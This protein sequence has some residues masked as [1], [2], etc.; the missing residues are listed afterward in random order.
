LILLTQSLTPAPANPQTKAQAQALLTEGTALYERGDFAGALDRFQAAY[1]IYPSPKLQFNIAQADRD[2]GRP[3]EAIEAFEKFLAQAPKSAPALLS[4]AYQSVADL[5]SKLGRIKIQCETSD[6]EVA[7]DGKTVGI[8]PL[9][10]PIWTLP[11]RHEVV[12]RHEGY[13][14]ISVTVAAGEHQTIVFESHRGTVLPATS[15]ADSAAPPATAT[16]APSSA[17][18]GPSQDWFSRQRWYVWATAGGTVAFTVGA[19]VAGLSA[20]SLFDDLRS[21]CGAAAGGCTPSQKDSLHTRATLTNVFWA[22][23]GVSAVTAAVSLYI[24]NRDAGV[25][26]AWRF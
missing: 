18:G 22:L 20:N 21:S 13:H 23:A 19:I 10:L 16:T 11:G 9:A 8:T 26:V 17:D 7:I 1:A 6:S 4:E 24:D 15:V 14:P 5:R 25:A 2:L 12:I 3:V